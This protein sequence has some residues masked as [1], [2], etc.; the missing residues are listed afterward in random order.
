M[1]NGVGIL[2]EMI[3][4]TAIGRKYVIGK[5]SSRI[6]TMAIGLRMMYAYMEDAAATSPTINAKTK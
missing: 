1:I 3:A 4:Q 5:H 2:E 6:M